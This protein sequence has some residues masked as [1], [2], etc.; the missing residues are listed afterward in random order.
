MFD[1]FYDTADLKYIKNNW[2]RLQDVVEPHHVRGVTTN[3]NAFEKVEM[4][5]LKEWEAQLSKLCELVSEIR[6]DDRGVVYVQAPNSR[7]SASQVLRW[8]EHIHKF[9][10]G[11]TKLGV[12][13][14]PF[15]E[16]LDVV[17]ELNQYME[18]NVTGI[19]DCATALSCLTY[20]VRYVSI[21]P[22]RMEE[23]G[24]Y[25]KEHVLFAQRRKTD[26]SEIIAGSMRTIEGL[27]WVCEAATV[28]TIGTRVWDKLLDPQQFNLEEI[29]TFN[30]RELR[31]EKYSPTI[32]HGN[33][34]L[35]LD[36]FQQMDI[37][38]RHA[39]KDFLAL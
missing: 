25:A 19:A 32:T 24:I 33:T 21:I 23:Q 9:N 11:N 8:A 20:D 39:H 14:P 30:A 35:S 37:C 1:F 18:T 16:I 34:Q 22:G 4:L 10:D 31:S 13:I 5:H 7:M 26:K 36:F 27:R 12:K 15:K 3:P 2:A 38:G 17:D 28:P 29:T 6:G